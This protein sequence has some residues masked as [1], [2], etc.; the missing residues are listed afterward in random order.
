[1]NSFLTRSSF[2]GLNRHLISQPSAKLLS[3]KHT[4]KV[5]EQA[6]LPGEPRF[7][8]ER[9]NLWSASGLKPIEGDCR[10]IRTLIASL[11][12][13]EKERAHVLDVL[14]FHVANPGVKITH[15]LMITGIQG[16]G[17]NTLFDHILRPIVAPGNLRVISGE[18]L[19]SRFN[20][21]L[22]DVQ[23]LVIDEVV[24]RDGWLVAN[25]MKP[26][27]TDDTILAE[28]KGV[29]RRNA[30]T[31]RLMVI[32]SNDRTP[33]PIEASDR[34][35][36]ISTFGSSNLSADFYSDLHAALEH[37]V[38]AFYAELLQRD[39]SSFKPK[40]APPITEAKQ[41]LQA[42]VR[43]PLERQLREMIEDMRGP[44]ACNLVMPQAVIYELRLAGHTLVTEQAVIKG[45]KD[46]G[47]RSLG[48]LPPRTHWTGRPRC[49]AIRQHEEM[50]AAGPAAW[51]HM[52]VES[53]T[54]HS[55]HRLPQA[56]A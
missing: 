17:K 22:V 28:A 19:L 12:P 16:S 35:N 3:Y 41:D 27:I 14:A 40:A 26:L 44:F 15:A 56:A 55:T 20:S 53:L 42:A 37:E 32:L 5:R 33:L 43:P 24:H 52:L 2:D 10:L 9:L 34:R 39:V 31:P 23:V 7:V 25:A 47:A 21:E 54:P 46:V 49:W 38:P 4:R 18:A 30:S 51:A 8:G 36:W 1:M 48:Q 29:N 11:F 6:Y 13:D 45:L 50:A